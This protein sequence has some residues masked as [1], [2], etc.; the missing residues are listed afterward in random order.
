[1]P[2]ATRA[3]AWP[4]PEPVQLTTEHGI[5]QAGPIEDHEPEALERLVDQESQRYLS[6]LQLLKDHLSSL[7]GRPLALRPSTP[8]TSCTRSTEST[9]L[10]GRKT[11]GLFGKSQIGVTSGVRWMTSGQWPVE[12]SVMAHR[13]G[14][15]LGDENS[16]ETFAELGPG[17]YA[18]VKAASAEWSLGTPWTTCSAATSP[19]ATRSAW[20]SS[21]AHRLHDRFSCYSTRGSGP[22]RRCRLPS[23]GSADTPRCSHQL[24]QVGD[25]RQV[26]GGCMAYRVRRSGRHAHRYP[27]GR[28]LGRA[29]RRI[30]SSP[31]PS[32]QANT[33]KPMLAYSA[34]RRV[35]AR[36]RRVPRGDSP[37][38]P[39]GSTG[40]HPSRGAPAPS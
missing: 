33:P 11:L 9:K 23:L 4:I 6:R 14:A 27:V 12:P 32:R 25:C 30:A 28:P 10:L 37:P 24:G 3:C 19:S 1:M 13:G 31:R 21:Q 7:G 5:Q 22:A 8:A 40:R 15:A 20:R 26:R 29:P 38:S 2:P 35:T 39:E 17:L 34:A 18:E 16:V 36:P